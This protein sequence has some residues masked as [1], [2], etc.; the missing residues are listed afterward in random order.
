VRALIRCSQGKKFR[1]E[2]RMKG[3]AGTV[4]YL[5]RLTPQSSAAFK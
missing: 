5:E 3:R 4:R 1:P 2:R